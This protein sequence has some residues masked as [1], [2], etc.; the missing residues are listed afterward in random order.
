M[1]NDDISIIDKKIEELIFDKKEHSFSDLK[2]KVEEILK[3][4]NIF[5]VEN[6]LN[7]KA[8]DMYLKNVINQRNNIKKAEEKRK[9]DNSKETKYTLI[10][11][12]CKKLEFENQEQLIK[13]VDELQIKTNLELKQILDSI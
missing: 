4:V 12:I 13:K 8:V 5:F 2:E 3:S 10:E 1:S 11:N 6:E 7:S 9:I